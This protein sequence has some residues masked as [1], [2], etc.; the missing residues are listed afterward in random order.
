[1]YGISSL[2]TS[3]AYRE[4]K[5][6]AHFFGHEHSCGGKTTEEMGIRFINGALCITTH[7]V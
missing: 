4:H 7:N 1:M 2:T 3:M 5:I 6:R